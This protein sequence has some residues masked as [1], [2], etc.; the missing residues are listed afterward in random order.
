M[1]NRPLANKTFDL[2]EYRGEMA[3][4][5]RPVD[6]EGMVESLVH[7]S[8]TDD[9]LH[10]GRNYL[11]GAHVATDRGAVEVVVKQF[12][13][14][15]LKRR[16]E[17]RRKGSKAERSWRAALAVAAA[18]VAT[19]E[20]LVWIESRLPEGPSF[21]VSRRL[22]D[23]LEAR[24]YFRALEAG[25]E[26]VSYP[27]LEPER[28]LAEI[29]RTIRRLHDAG[30]WHRDLSIG[31][32]L[33]VGTRDGGPDQVFVIDLNRARAASRLTTMQRTR[34]LCR[35]R[36][37]R[38]DLQERFLE[39]YWGAALSGS[40]RQLYKLFFHGFLC[41]VWLKKMLRR[42]FRGLR[43]M[44]SPRH[45]HVHIPQAPVEA[46][47][48]D[49]VVWDGLSDQPHQH[50]TRLE[51]L[52][53]RLGDA[54]LHG[55]EWAAAIGALPRIRRRY[56]QLKA[57]LH[58]KPGEWRGMGIALRPWPAAPDA[59]LAAL[60]D[61]GTRHVLLRL[62][63]WQESHD[64]EEELA[65]E[66]HAR[67]YEITYVLAQNRDLVRSPD[68][69]RDAVTELS[70]RFGSF[71]SHFQVGQAINR[72]KWGI[73]NYREYL[74][75]AAAAI[76][77][78][79]RQPG[80]QILGPGV[81]DYEPARTAGI[82]N[83][84]QQGVDFDILASLLYVDR[85]GAPENEQLGF[86]TVD[87]AL[88]MKAI[89]DTSPHCGDRSWITEVNWPLWEGPHSPA[90]RKVSV[91]EEAQASYLAR[92]YLLALGTG[93]V[94]RVYWWQLVARGYG[95]SLDDGTG[96]LGRRRS[97]ASFATLYRL[98][99]GATFLGP[100]PAV[101]PA[102]LYRFRDVDGGDWIA[103]WTA[104]DGTHSVRLPQA[105]SSAVSRDGEE[106]SAAGRDVE[107]GGSPIYFRLETG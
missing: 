8:P 83:V 22:D 59:L 16:W 52:A 57:E 13:N 66:L 97:F 43:E 12:R 74:D 69:W 55:R 15:G 18:G 6:P 98:F 10:W 23:F 102:H 76:E 11:Y 27:H 34:D 75:L 44:L 17:R 104:D 46:S 36:I 82:L 101:T 94:E 96:D 80:R 79:R 1:R 88:Q 37:F 95:L 33:L 29:G 78:L 91:D 84:S 58:S 39:A 64:H 41:K 14:Q 3:E 31:N 7:P 85:R 61:L 35:L 100:A 103:G 20:P 48:R 45:P 53:V 71:G 89:A 99:E 87:K 81:I 32:V 30:I 60:A 77:I 25:S 19:P 40:R 107:I 49:R 73:W 56:R 5:L 9:T 93:S 67:G 47:T 70:E 86:D 72:S 65:R 38:P 2:A 54:P 62:Q 92:Y 42:P 106:L 21:F 105:A 50:A 68:R 24:F 63:A 26:K 90:G 51:R 4:S 28:V